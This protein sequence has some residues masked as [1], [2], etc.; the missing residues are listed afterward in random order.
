MSIAT[1]IP[2]IWS[3]RLL[4]HLDNALVAKNFF[5]T[6]YEGEITDAGNTVKIN[7]IGN[8]TISNYIRNTDMTPPEEL[9]MVA[10]ELLIDQA[11]SFNFQIDDIDRVQANADLMNAAMERS[12][13][14]LAEVEDTFLFNRIATTIFT[15]AP[16]NYIPATAIVTPDDAFAML[17]QLRTLL[18]KANVPAMGRN[19]AAA[20]EFVSMLL[21]DDR[22]TGTGGTFAEGTLLAGS[23]GRAMGFNIFEVNTTPGNNTIIAGHALGATRADQ[24]VKTE[25]YRM[26]KRF[27]DGLKGLHVYG[28][29]V[30]IP[31]AFA[32]AVANVGPAD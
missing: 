15:A 11:K 19:L 4:M 12:G 14:S 30:T 2:T 31:T 27:A 6:D 25:A 17:V 18:T 22:F 26:E 10:Q 29:K 1:F 24:I 28:A 32:V 7:Q 21:K 13:Y 16:G 9:N 8:I 23:I 20:P 5:N 3:A